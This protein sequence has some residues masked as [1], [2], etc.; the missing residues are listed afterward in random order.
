MKMNLGSRLLGNRGENGCSRYQDC[1]SWFGDLWYWLIGRFLMMTLAALVSDERIMRVWEC[2]W[3]W[4]RVQR[5]YMGCMRAGLDLV[6][7]AHSVVATEMVVVLPKRGTWCNI[8]SRS[9]WG[10][11][12]PGEMDDWRSD[13][14]GALMTWR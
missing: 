2:G 5:W 10:R 9:M 6:S 8:F 3:L 1:G 13:L 7:G 4:V 14:G 12:K 11:F